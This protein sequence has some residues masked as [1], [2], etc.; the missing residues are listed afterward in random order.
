M[1]MNFKTFRNWP[2]YT[3]ILIQNGSLKYYVENG[4]K[5]S[6]LKDYRTFIFSFPP[7]YKC[8]KNNLSYGIL[9]TQFP[10]P[11]I[12]WKYRVYVCLIP[13]CQLNSSEIKFITQFLR[14][15]ISYMLD[16]GLL[17]IPFI[18]WKYPDS[19]QCHTDG[20]FK[21]GVHMFVSHYLSCITLISEV[22]LSTCLRCYFWCYLWQVIMETGIWK[23]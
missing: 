18:R 20:K 11:A 1:W 3:L 21:L 7:D 19:N 15:F 22:Y 10:F 4:L 12:N 13:I 16:H 2:W 14:L 5:L 23:A 9:G 8:W 17:G 6:F